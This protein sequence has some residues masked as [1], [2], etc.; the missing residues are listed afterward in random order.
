[1]LAGASPMHT[2]PTA[3]LIAL[4]VAGPG[5]A[6][7]PEPDPAR[8]ALAY[9]GWER[10]TAGDG[11]P[12]DRILSLCAA[13]GGLWVGTEDGLARY[14]GSTWT[15]WTQ[16]DG[17][18]W[19]AI[20][21]IDVDLYSRDVWLGTWGGGLVRFTGGRFDQ[22]DQFNSGLAGNL[23]FAVKVVGDS[24]WAA[25]NAGLSVYDT[26]L[27]T[28][29]LH[30][31]QRADAPETAVIDLCRDGAR[32]CAAAWCG[33]LW[34]NNPD[35]NT[36]QRITA[37]GVR[38]QA[39]TTQGIAVSGDYFWWAQQGMLLRHEVGSGWSARPLGACRD[40]EEPVN[41][42]AASDDGTVCLGTDRGLRVVVDFT[43]GTWLS[44]LGTGPGPVS[45]VT[46]T[47]GADALDARHLEPA[48]PDPRVRC[49]AAQGPA[50]WVGTPR[51]L[52]R[53]AGRK[54]LA[55]LPP[56]TADTDPTDRRAPAATEPA[57]LRIGALKP[58]ERMMDLPGSP[59]GTNPRLR[60]VDT[61]AMN[62]A[63]E[64]AN[65]RGGYRGRIPFALASGPQGW[66][67]GWGWTTAEDNFH[68]LAGL[69]DVM[70]IVAY[71]GPG[72]CMTTAVALRSG[73]PVVNFAPTAPTVDETL[74]PWIFRCRDDDARRL[75][76][77]LD[78]LFD[79]LG[80]T[81]L[82][83]LG[84]SGHL[85]SA[86]LDWWIAE[87]AARGNPVV[88]DLWCDAG[89]GSFDT[90]LDAIDHSGAEAVLTWTDAPRS[91]AILRA[92]RDA[93]M[94]Q[95]FV[96]SDRIIGDQFIT[97][98][99]PRPGVVVAPAPAPRGADDTAEARFIDDYT[100]R[101][102]RPPTPG[103]FRTYEA[104]R[105]LLE[106]VEAAGPDREAV[107]RALADLTRDGPGR[108]EPAV[109]GRLRGGEWEVDTL[110]DVGPP[111]P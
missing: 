56:A 25:T 57:A 64:K 99:G 79:T 14:D 65:D 18:P 6:A 27:D 5:P 100:K 49:V 58:G 66:Y 63:I 85:A 19:P 17:L 73:L 7:P 109:L 90:V 74:N 106:A 3:A 23:V 4:C 60:W 34:V 1:M 24:V 32:L 48:L 77:V 43:N 61:M 102:R 30:F 82:G 54:P 80:Y 31:E 108:P 46:L 89:G 78:Y 95:A 62:L 86:P 111:E 2:A 59:S 52:A 87:A 69:S 20:S 101:F 16:D 75:G 36:W 50:L 67:L 92:M 45:T 72:S 42:L 76:I 104:A 51:G 37:P 13:D 107:R 84:D 71:M 103:A 26:A 28:W 91:A 81:R 55:Q 12:H 21:A 110:S 38:P 9:V 39:D 15:A 105:L 41:C 33:G 44:Y 53:A 10:F 22:I 68:D 47:R 40:G 70:G 29:D 98:A 8:S 94:A 83:V 96:G 11:L 35:L 88:A 97:L 93:G